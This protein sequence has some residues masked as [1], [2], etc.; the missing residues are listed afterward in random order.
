M[1]E[2]NEK[3]EKEKPIRF[4]VPMDATDEDLL[5]VIDELKRYSAEAKAK[6]QDKHLQ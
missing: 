4:T 3:Q 5:A 6:K 2:K 1:T